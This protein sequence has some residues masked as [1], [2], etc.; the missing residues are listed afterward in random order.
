MHVLAWL[1]KYRPVAS[2]PLGWI[3]FQG[4]L[5]F[6]PSSAFISGLFLLPAL[7]LGSLKRKDSY[8]ADFWNYPFLGTA[9]LMIVGC[10]RA[11]SGWLA[12]IGLANWLP[13][14]WSFW[15]FQ[16]YLTTSVSRRRAGLWL[17]TGTVPVVITGF[18]QLWLGWH[19]PWQ[20]LNGLVVWFVAPGG[21][22]NGRLSG[23]FDYANITGAWLMIVWPFCLAALLQPFLQRLRRNV[24]F[25]LAVSIVASL[26]LTDSRNAW[27]GLFLVIPFVLGPAQWIWLF[28]FL[29]V[30]FIPLGLAVIPGVETELQ[31]MARRIVPENIWAR[32]TDLKHAEQ[33]FVASARLPIWKE[34]IT[35]L[36]EK[37]WFGWGAAAFPVLYSLRRNYWPGHAHNLP[38][39]VAVSH[40]WPVMLLIVGVV[41]ALLITVVRRGVLTVSDKNSH[42]LGT[43]IF[44][45]A[46][47]AATFALI[48]WHGF[49]IPLFD[50]RLNMAG[51]VL[52]AG[53]RCLAI[54][55]NSIKQSVH[56][57]FV[58]DAE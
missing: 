19:G 4:G 48:F 40:G 33:R 21:Q 57:D 9:I 37:P 7:V 5:F 20:M 17:V 51:W 26:F 41:L 6:L 12:W 45:R 42:Y 53:L 24:I 58:S 46:W 55:L 32:L 2:N 27:G 31:M 38:L 50:S 39:E 13:Y 28:P 10:F 54:S 35:L 52:L 16:P 43:S 44:D 23:L 47:W 34:A 1:H 8:W 36:A 3:C 18:G 56:S 11:Q 14:F 15:A 22:P 49:D 30:I 25:I 29:L